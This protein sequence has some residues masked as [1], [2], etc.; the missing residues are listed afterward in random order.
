MISIKV[1]GCE[2]SNEERDTLRQ[3]FIYCVRSGILP[4]LHPALV[5]LHF[6]SVEDQLCD[7][8]DTRLLVEIVIEHKVSTVI[9]FSPRREAF[10][11]YA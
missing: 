1:L 3:A 2:V 10:F 7:K 11:E 5:Q 9:F 4:Q 8:D 6:V